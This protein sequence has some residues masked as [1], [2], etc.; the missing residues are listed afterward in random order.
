MSY[1][2]GFIAAVPNAN[3]EKFRQHAED[4][5][6]LFREKGALK[7]M[8]NWGDDV[9]AGEVT[10]FPLAVQKKDDESVVFSWIVWPSKDVRDQA[11]KVLMEDPRMAPDQN[12]MPFDGKRMI[13]GGFETILDI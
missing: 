3:R 4:M 7:I 10:S 9:P 13:Y 12:P 11:W 6:K 2:D 8:E 1:V 5:G